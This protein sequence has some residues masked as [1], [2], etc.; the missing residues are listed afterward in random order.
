MCTRVYGARVR[1][2]YLLFIIYFI[3]YLFFAE[4]KTGKK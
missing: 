3:F 4:Q 2:Y 1:F